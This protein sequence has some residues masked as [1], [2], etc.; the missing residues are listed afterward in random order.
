VF[1]FTWGGQK[2]FAFAPFFD[3]FLMAIPSERNV[4]QTI[5]KGRWKVHRA[6]YIVSKFCERENVI[7]KTLSPT[8]WSHGV[9][10]SKFQNSTLTSVSNKSPSHKLN[11]HWIFTG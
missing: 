2:T 6:S 8:F 3:D 11:L 7:T 1:Y 10:Y 5:G 4:T 9:Q